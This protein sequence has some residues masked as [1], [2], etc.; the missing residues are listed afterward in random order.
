MEWEAAYCMIRSEGYSVRSVNNLSCWRLKFLEVIYLY[1]SSIHCTCCEVM[2]V[3]INLPQ[4]T[5]SIRITTRIR[6]RLVGI[7]WFLSR[8]SDFLQ[9][10]FSMCQ[11]SYV[12]HR[13]RK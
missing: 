2:V 4:V 10:E 11:S 1:I 8:S 12:K 5:C 3:I 13:K 7:V 6:T 9:V